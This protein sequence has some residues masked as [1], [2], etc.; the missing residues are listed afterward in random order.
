M[1]QLAAL[2]HSGKLKPHILHVFPFEEMAQ[3]HLQL[4]SHHT[5]G[6]VVLNRIG[7]R[8]IAN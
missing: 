1:E 4:E 3:A 6:K 7:Q 5:I 8:K 2:L